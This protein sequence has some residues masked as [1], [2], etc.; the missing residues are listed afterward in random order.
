MNIFKMISK[1][2]LS[3]C[4]ENYE[5]FENVFVTVL[6]RHALR[7]TK[8]FRGYQKPHVNKNLRK[9]IMKRSELK[10]KAN[11]TTKRYFRLQKATKPCSQIK[12]REKN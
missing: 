11:R 8:I 3:K 12:E 4:P 7:K 2:G 9:A 10:S 6:N 1:N 5:S